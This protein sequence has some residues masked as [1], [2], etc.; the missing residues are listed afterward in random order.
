MKIEKHSKII[1]SLKERLKWILVDFLSS[2]FLIGEL[3][4]ANSEVN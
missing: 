4:K 2:Y 3:I 1:L